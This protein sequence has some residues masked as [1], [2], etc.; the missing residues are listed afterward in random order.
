MEVE[1]VVEKPVY[2][3]ESRDQVREIEVKVPQVIWQ[4]EFIEI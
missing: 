1:R 3:Y 2:I 4:K